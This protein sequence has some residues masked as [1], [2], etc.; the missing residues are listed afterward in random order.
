MA[1]PSKFTAERK[2]IILNALRIGAPLKDAA[3]W[4][5]IDPSQ[6]TRWIQRGE[7]AAE[8]TSW[9]NF[10]DEVRVA[11]AEPKMKALGIVNREMENK[12]DLAWKFVERRVKGYAPPAPIAPPAPKSA[13]VISL[14]FAGVP[15]RPQLVPNEAEE[16]ELV[17]PDELADAAPA[18]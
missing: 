4:A 11:Q 5:G 17:E 3:E 14:S 12:A 13:T 18:D 15:A 9:R 16:G 6:L 2:E 1:M 7:K 10:H 8:G